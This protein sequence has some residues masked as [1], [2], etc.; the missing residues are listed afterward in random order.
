MKKKVLSWI[1]FIILTALIVFGFKFKNN[2]TN[3]ASGIIKNQISANV[4]SAEYSLV[5][6]LYN[7]TRN[8]EKYNI[9]FL[10]FGATG[11]IAC[12]KMEVVM[13]EIRQK[14]PTKVNVKFI[15][16][17]IAKNQS[18][19]SFFGIATIPTQILLNNK[20]VEIYRHTGYITT[21]KLQQVILNNLN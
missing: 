20:G 8:G 14:F 21:T 6:S 13:S 4:V 12:K 11:C 3:Y 16:L 1:V 9:T 15:N 19:M 5:D 18:L 17:I 2:L 10:E 7:Y